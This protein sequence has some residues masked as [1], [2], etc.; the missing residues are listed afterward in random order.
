MAIGSHIGPYRIVRQ[1]G[2]GG[3]GTI[4]EALH[5]TIER[6]VVVKVLLSKYAKD[7]T[8]VSR[9]MN[10]A[11]AVNRVGHP[12]LV[13]VYDANQLPDG[14]VYIMME[15]LHGETLSERARRR[16][17]SIKES[18]RLGRQIAGALAAAHNKGIIHRDLKPDN[19][20]IVSDPDTTA[21]ERS[22]I[23][24]FGIAKLI[25]PEGAVGLSTCP[26]V[27]LG[28]PLYMSPEQCRGAAGV[29]DR[30]DVY[31]LGVMLFWMLTGRAPFVG[32]LGD[33]I[34]K[35]MF[36]DLPPLAELCPGAPSALVELISD[37][38]AKLPQQRPSMS[39]VTVTLGEI[40]SQVGASE[41]PASE[42]SLAPG[43]LSASSGSSSERSAAISLPIQSAASLP[44]A[45]P[46]AF[47]LGSRPLPPRSFWLTGLALAVGIL[48][49]TA[50]GLAR[51]YRHPPAP[52]AVSRLAALPA[53][54]VAATAPAPAPLPQRTP[55]FVVI[56]STPP[57]APVLR[58]VD[59]RPLG[60]TPWLLTKRLEPGDEELL[61][62]LPGYAEQRVRLPLD[63]DF[64]ADV[65]LVPTPSEAERLRLPKVRLAVRPSSPLKKRV[66]SDDERK[67][68]IELE[69]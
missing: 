37:L 63:A 7:A 54:G 18:L 52:T 42:G 23:L 48:L 5:E 58:A 32:S 20:M 25:E 2:A 43:T 55:P 34:T 3:M 50:V 17:F 11:R 41:S 45:T 28:T 49:L 36:A 10:E 39:Q 62:A 57:G 51:Q 44:A 38:M 12:G 35:H 65:A 46:Q 16:R 61:L 66:I 40:E 19:V 67:S 64:T 21:G 56:R 8:S 4:Y 59:R 68:K 13:Q 47:A 6:R 29:D 15:L 30:T 26:E 14:T 60:Q 24:D 9:L 53:P 31:S 1:L 33:V 27:V 69:E 22:K